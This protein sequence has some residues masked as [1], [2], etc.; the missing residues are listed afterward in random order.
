MSNKVQFVTLGDAEYMPR[1]YTE[2]FCIIA[3]LCT[4]ESKLPVTCL[5]N[6]NQRLISFD[7]T[8]SEWNNLKS[9]YADLG[10]YMKCCGAQAIPKTSK[11]GTQFFAHKTDACGEGKE[12]IEHI[13]CKELIVLGARDAG[14]L[15][16]PEESGI[17]LHNNP[18]VADVLCIKNNVKFAFEVQLAS[19]T[20][21][22]YKR[23]T[24]RYINSQVSCLW[25]IPLKRKHPIAEQM[26][27]DRIN[28]TKR[29]DV[30]G[31]HPD[32]QDMP[33]FQVDISDLENILVF[34]PWHHGNGPFH[35]PLREF[36]NGV[37][38]GRMNFNNQRWCWST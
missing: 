5:T 9:N 8:P 33:V 30:I 29:S 21:A 28:S 20:F 12:S 23:R 36:A 15:A 38:S 1:Y 37:L 13:R 25:F 35:I 16:N 32:R 11:L 18:W 19:Q 24:E 6:F 2:S 34:F 4:K 27:L 31:H 26:I 7:Y 22:E 3:Q 14:W 10:L 17:D